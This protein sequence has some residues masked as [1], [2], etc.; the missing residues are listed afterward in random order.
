M[1]DE[2]IPN[3]V[4]NE[5]FELVQENAHKIAEMLFAPKGFWFF[6]HSNEGVRFSSLLTSG[7]RLNPANWSKGEW[8]CSFTCTQDLDDV[9]EGEEIEALEEWLFSLTPDDLAHM[10]SFPSGM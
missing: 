10:I 9:Q 7:T 2:I 8:V 4:L 1:N 5:V 6:I 3:A